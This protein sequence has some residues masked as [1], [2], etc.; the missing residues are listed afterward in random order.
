[1]EYIQ[2]HLTFDGDLPFSFVYHQQKERKEE[3]PDH[4]H[5]WYELIY[6]HAGEAT[7]FIDQHVIHLKQGD[8]ILVPPNIIH[9]TMIKFN[10]LLTTSVLYLFPVHLIERNVSP[11]IF[12][13]LFHQTERKSN[14]R[15]SLSIDKQKTIEMYME[16]I[17]SEKRSMNVFWEEVAF[18]YIIQL[19]VQL[20]RWKDIFNNEIEES[21]TNPSWL[22]TV[23]EYINDHL[24]ET[25]H[26]K[27]LSSQIY[28]SAVHFSKKFKQTVG[29]TVSDFLMKKRILR[30]K[31]LLKETEESVQEVAELSGYHSIPYFHRTFKKL[32]GKTP[33]EY[34][35]NNRNAD[36][37]F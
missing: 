12:F 31:K 1:M 25:I 17:D 4:L 15:H 6:I 33:A 13:D 8:L 21:S 3:W 23:I 36:L 19:M 28:M 37:P 34:R 32:V 2:K 24:H 26:L 11:N 7:F 27:D 5:E 10:H 22:N 18:T 9:R 35:K 14:F 20:H 30:A 29:M 16:L